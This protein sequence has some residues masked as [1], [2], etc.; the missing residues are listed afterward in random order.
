LHGEL[1]ALTNVWS[2]HQ[3]FYP[4]YIGYLSTV[5]GPKMDDSELDQLQDRITG[6][7]TT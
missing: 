7:K 1:G 4:E 6:N 3:E 5:E 2:S